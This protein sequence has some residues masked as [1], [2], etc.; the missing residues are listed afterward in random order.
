[1]PPIR[2]FVAIPI[3]QEVRANLDELI[4]DLKKFREPV[5][6][7]RPD[8]LHITLRFLGNQEPDRLEELADRLQEKVAA[9]A[10]Q[11]EMEGLGAFPNLSR[12]RVIWAGVGI[13]QDKMLSLHGQ[14]EEAL[15]VW[16]C[17]PE[18]RKFTSHL[19]LGRVKGPIREKKFTEFM[20]NR[21]NC[22]LG[23]TQVDRVLIMQSNLLPRGAEY[24]VL[25]ELKLLDAKS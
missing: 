3:N 25:H 12:P 2:S 24:S 18:S 11:I 6:W 17:E 20:A 10:F 5:K 23:E 22:G 16:G 7:V 1:M 8:N 4:A 9:E 19:T 21:S 14:V 15:E 13:G